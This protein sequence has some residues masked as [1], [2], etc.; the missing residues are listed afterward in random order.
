MAFGLDPVKGEFHVQAKFEN[1]VGAKKVF[2][3]SLENQVLFNMVRG[4]A[5]QYL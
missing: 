1:G 4:L 2:K 3:M 5:E